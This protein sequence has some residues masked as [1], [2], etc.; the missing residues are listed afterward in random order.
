MKKSLVALFTLFAL[1][2]MTSHAELYDKA[3]IVSVTPVYRMVPETKRE[4]WN[5]EVVIPASQRPAER[6]VAGQIIGGTVGG[7]LG[8]QIGQGSGKTAATIAGAVGGAVIGDRYANGQQPVSTQE[9]VRQVQRCNNVTHEVSM[10]DGYNVTYSYAGRTETVKSKYNP[11][12]RGS[13]KVR[14]IPVFDER[15]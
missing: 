9:E 10:A 4:C 15:N 2:P 1:L 3:T 14:I 8:H 5:E 6:T 11:G 12:D 13:I 7:L